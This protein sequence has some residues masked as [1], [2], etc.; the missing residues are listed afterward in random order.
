MAK[1]P[2]LPTRLQ[3]SLGSLCFFNKPEEADHFP[4]HPGVNTAKGFEGWKRQPT[5][6][7][8][9]VGDLKSRLVP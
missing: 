1:L 6:E 7:L 8:N 5:P 2:P 4:P 3:N 9:Q